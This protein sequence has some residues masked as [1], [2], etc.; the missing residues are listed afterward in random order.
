MAAGTSNCFGR[1]NRP[2]REKAFMK[3]DPR[4]RRV[5][6]TTKQWLPHFLPLLR[7]YRRQLWWAVLAMVVDAS[8]T[9]FRP[10]PLKIVIDRV[11]SHRST[12]VPF[13]SVCL[14]NT[15]LHPLHLPYRPSVPRSLPPLTTSLP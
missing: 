9:V 12:R 14:D 1:A 11:L 15:I 3:S 4:K 6:T 8:L 10:W 7:S 13:L 5:G 2:K